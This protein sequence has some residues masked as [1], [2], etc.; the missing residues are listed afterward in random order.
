MEKDL[1]CWSGYE[2]VPG[3]TPGEPGSCR[4]VNDFYYMEGYAENSTKDQFMRKFG[5]LDGAEMLYDSTQ[6]AKAL[7][8]S[9]QEYIDETYS[10]YHSMVNMSPSELRK[11]SENECSGKAGLSKAP[12]TRN[13]RLLE[14]PKEKWTEATAKSANRTISYLSRSGGI[15]GGNKVEGCGMTKNSLARK[16]W[17]KK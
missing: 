15:K 4:P 6:D 1:S 9:G 5:D 16:N 13:I 8:S 10:K 14:T 2:R 12:I 17:G 11:W 7:D 3:T